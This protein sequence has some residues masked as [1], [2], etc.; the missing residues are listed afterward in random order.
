MTAHTI[1]STP[2]VWVPFEE[3]EQSI[4]G[5]LTDA[6]NGIQKDYGLNLIEKQY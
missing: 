2:A 6:V 3:Q 5:W 4:A 1:I